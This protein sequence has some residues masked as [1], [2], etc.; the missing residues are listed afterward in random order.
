MAVYGLITPT[1]VS[2]RQEEA[3]EIFGVT[4]KSRVDKSCPNENGKN[5]CTDWVNRPVHLIYEGQDTGSGIPIP[6]GGYG[7]G[8]D[9]IYMPLPVYMHFHENGCYLVFYE[10]SF[11]SIFDFASQSGDWSETCKI[12]FEC[13]S[14]RYYFIS[15][16]PADALRRFTQLTGRPGLLRNGAWGYHHSRW[17]YRTEKEIRSLASGFASHDLPVSAI[18]LDI[19]H[20]KGYRTLTVDEN[21]FPD[22][23]GLANELDLQGIKLISIV[24]PGVKIDSEY[25]IYYEG[26]RNNRF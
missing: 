24:N 2:L 12:T 4:E 14:L 18:H 22:L 7:Q 5:A 8:V 26:L 10:N 25:P 9:P 23:A 11:Q 21:R 6:R 19:D 13:G 1:A 20:M 3:P 15:G 16:H 17:G